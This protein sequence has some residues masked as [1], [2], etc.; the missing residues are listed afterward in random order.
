MKV[1][2]AKQR[3]RTRAAA[4]SM[5]QMSLGATRIVVRL[6]G[7]HIYAQLV[8]PDGRVLAAAATPQRELRESLHGKYSNI[9]AAESVGKRLAERAAGLELGRLAFDRG[10][11][12][13]HG[14]VRALAEALR[15][16]GMKF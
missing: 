1:I 4:S 16:A 7:R 11:R 8:A 3:R 5:R 9:A 10:G 12:K 15:A 6:S 14:R 13:Y 2:S